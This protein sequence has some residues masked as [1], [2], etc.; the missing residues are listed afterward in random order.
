MS[1]IFTRKDDKNGYRFK[2]AS[3]VLCGDK[4][5]QTC[6]CDDDEDKKCYGAV[7]EVYDIEMG[8]AISYLGRPRGKKPRDEGFAFVNRLWLKRAIHAGLLHGCI[9]ETGKYYFS[10]NEL[11]KLRK[12]I[13]AYDGIDPLDE[14]AVADYVFRNGEGKVEIPLPNNADDYDKRFHDILF[15]K[16]V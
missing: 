11:D 14:M 7:D 10:L 12:N 4:F 2:A 8:D 9:Y 15:C 5:Q 3:G 6:V 13:L 1:L 16:R